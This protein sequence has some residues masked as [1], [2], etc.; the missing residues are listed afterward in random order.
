MTLNQDKFLKM[1]DNFILKKTFK[2]FSFFN[3]Y[4]NFEQILLNEH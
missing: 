1:I 3:R 2:F 4:L